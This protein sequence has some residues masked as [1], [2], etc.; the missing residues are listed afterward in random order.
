MMDSKLGAKWA[1]DVR[2]QMEM[3]WRMSSAF[4]EWDRKALS[5]HVLDCSWAYLGLCF[6]H[7]LLV[8]WWILVVVVSCGDPSDQQHMRRQS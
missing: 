7:F 5:V 4:C 8:L 2:E 6:W 3:D 1:G